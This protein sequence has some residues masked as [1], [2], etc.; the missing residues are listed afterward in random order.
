MRNSERRCSGATCSPE[1]GQPNK[2]SKTAAE[3]SPGR[4]PGVNATKR[5]SRPS[6]RA[7][8]LGTEPLAVASGSHLQI[9]PLATASG[10][11]PVAPCRAQ[12]I[13]SHPHPGLTRGATCCRPLNA[14]WL[15]A[16]VIR[17]SL[18][19]ALTSFLHFYFC[20]VLLHRRLMTRRRLLLAD[21]RAVAIR[22]TVR[23]LELRKLFFNRSDLRIRSFL[24]VLV[25]HRA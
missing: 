7:A 11:V 25:A 21:V 13:R 1:D 4:K 24:T 17:H 14:G 10:S 5:I 2:P 23:L 6:K 9:Y 19:R 16:L 12:I 3:C 22:A 8:E 18:R 15:S 20:L